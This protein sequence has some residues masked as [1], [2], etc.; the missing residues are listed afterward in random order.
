MTT[1]PTIEARVR[2]F[3]LKTVPQ[4]GKRG[5]KDEEKWLESGLL[6]SFG[7]LDLVQFLEAEFGIHVS[8]DE[9]LPES[10][11]SLRAVV[12]FVETKL[13]PIVLPKQEST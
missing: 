3:M 10:F 9:L 12:N 7:I 6:D 2:E 4:V 11:E 5:L 8:D 1:K 13:S